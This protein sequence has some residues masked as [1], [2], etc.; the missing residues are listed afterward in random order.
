MSNYLGS[1][2]S[3]NVVVY[4]QRDTSIPNAVKSPTR[5]LLII[6]QNKYNHGS[7]LKNSANQMAKEATLGS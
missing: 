4:I 2:I 3:K 5:I 6:K 1:S 7:N